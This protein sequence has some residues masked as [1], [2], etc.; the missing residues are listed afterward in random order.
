MNRPG[1][2]GKTSYPTRAEAERARKGIAAKEVKPHK[3]KLRKSIAGQMQIYHCCDGCGG[4]HL[5][6][7]RTV[8]GPRR[9]HH[10]PNSLIA[11][12]GRAYAAMESKQ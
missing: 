4:Y 11:L 12:A 6:R 3:K 10:G 1:C 9:P 5:G 8:R 7:P 2:N